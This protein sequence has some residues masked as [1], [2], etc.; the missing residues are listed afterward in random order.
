MPDLSSSLPLKV[1]RRLARYVPTR[2][3]LLRAQRPVVSF[4][5][6]DVPETAYTNGARLLDD[7]GLRGTFYIA[8]GICG[9]TEDHWRVL[10]RDQVADLAR[11]G[12]EIGCHTNGHVAVQTLDAA[13]LAEDDRQ[14]R[15]ALREICG[16]VPLRS[17]AFPFGNA[18]LARKFQLQGQYDTCRGIHVGTNRGLIDLAMLRVQE[19]YDSTTGKA[20]VDRLL[21]DVQRRGGWL[22]F[23]THD[24]AATPCNIG[25]T[26]ELLDYALKSVTTRGITCMTVARAL[27][28][29]K[30]KP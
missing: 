27:T 19:L 7:Y 18:G 5:F 22:I 30:L 6:D 21:D 25:C 20:G 10:T 28:E 13:A 29:L 17:F 16:D 12:H 2:P 23:Y 14:C 4:T 1:S 9:K 26:P 24:V 3:R 11:R 15:A 8:P